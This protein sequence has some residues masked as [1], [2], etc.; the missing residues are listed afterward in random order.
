MALKEET[1]SLISSEDKTKLEMVKK[2]LKDAKE[3]LDVKKLTYEM[4]EGND[5]KVKNI[6][7][8]SSM[9]MK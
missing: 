6:N 5:L 7:A 2:Q 8:A 4:L 9:E 3:D 1:T